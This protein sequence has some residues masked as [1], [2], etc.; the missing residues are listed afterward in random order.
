MSSSPQCSPLTILPK[1]PKMGVASKRQTFCAE[2]KSAKNPNFRQ[3]GQ[4]SKSNSQNFLKYE[5]RCL[6][7]L[8]IVLFFS[9]GRTCPICK[10]VLSRQFQSFEVDIE[11]LAKQGH[12][13]LAH[14][15]HKYE[16][17]KSKFRGPF[18]RPKYLE[19]FLK[20][21]VTNCRS[22]ERRQEHFVHEINV[23]GEHIFFYRL[24]IRNN[25]EDPEE[26]ITGIFVAGEPLR[27]WNQ[28]L[29]EA[30]FNHRGDLH[31]V[32]PSGTG[33]NGHDTR[34]WERINEPWVEDPGS[35]QCEAIKRCKFF[36][37]F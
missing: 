9:E 3:G 36:L 24:F 13:R 21:V 18:R 1:L 11:T 25:S 27:V 37:T 23:A 30:W 12:F 7:K 5:S 16:H 19:S 29:V 17:T 6:P 10:P 2:S 35:K 33:R 4:G 22:L 32:F 20:E 26:N 15:E 14:I 28:R 8:C 31:S 34:E